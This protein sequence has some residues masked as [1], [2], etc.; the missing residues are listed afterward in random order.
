MSTV[1]QPDADGIREDRPVTDPQLA[2]PHMWQNPAEVA[3]WLS[4][5]GEAIQPPVSIKRV[6]VGQSNITTAVSDAAGREWVMR[7]PPKGTAPATAHDIEREAQILRALAPTG[8]P[9]PHVIG[10][11]RGPTGSAFLMM[12]KMP[13]AALET[14]EDAH[15]LNPDS[16]RKLGQEVATTLGRLHRLDPDLLGLPRSETPYLVR[17][18]HR[19]SQSWAHHGIS[20]PHDPEWRAVRSQLDDRI[21]PPAKPVIMHGDFRLSNLLVVG[22]SISAV[23]DWELCAVGDPMA[24]LAWLLDD[25]RSPE[26]AAIAMPSP[27]RA[28]GFPNRDEMIATYCDITGCDAGHID[29]YRAFSQ[30]RAASLL[31]GV[32]RRRRA[33]VMG[34]HASVD[35]DLLD[36][37]IA[38]L[39]HSATAHL[40]RYS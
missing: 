15:R 29:Y 19:V 5:H 30:W 22:S 38:V 12:E 27:T 34:S 35:I 8:L 17:Q 14:E 3:E 20:S 7:E 21:P 40:G 23:L 18:L 1:A 11:G 13:G 36:E 9:V 10:T 31:Q 24:D 37:S 2:M 32:L 33:G 28:G 39:L 6:G 25:W 16:R 4:G 26:E